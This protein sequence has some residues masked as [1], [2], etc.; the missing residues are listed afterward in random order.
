MDKATPS[1]V[2]GLRHWSPSST[3][4]FLTCPTL[5]DANRRLKL[6][7]EP[8]SPGLVVGHAVQAGLTAFY[9]SRDD[10]EARAAALK[11]L[12]D[13]EVPE[14]EVERLR[15]LIERGVR[16]GI[17]KTTQLDGMN[18]L[19]AEWEVSGRRIDVVLR[20]QATGALIIDDNK[21][22]LDL[23]AQY[24]ESRRAEW[25]HEWQALDYAWHVE[26]V[27][28]E[29]VQQVRQ[30]LIVLAPRQMT[31]LT[32]LTITPLRLA[33]W[34]ARAEAAWRQMDAIAAGA[35]AWVNTTVCTN[36]RIHYG[37]RCPMYELCHL[38]DGDEQAA[39]V[40]YERK[41]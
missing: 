14:P 5:W 4:Q 41:V 29:P 39:S 8:F 9:T 12:D 22:T 16:V 38:A 31:K 6:R 35:D 23:P 13:A 17:G 3:K 32:P 21:V 20:E 24:M 34:I 2:N 19:A 37:H 26:Q 25:A 10:D 7:V 1:I 28:G 36:T 18:V 40:Y 15:V 27:Q 30:H 11:D 33:W